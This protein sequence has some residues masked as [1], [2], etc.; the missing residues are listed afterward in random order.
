MAAEPSSSSTCDGVKSPCES[1]RFGTSGAFQNRPS[2][3]PRRSSATSGQTVPMTSSSRRRPARSS[4]IECTEAGA[5]VVCS[6]ASASAEARTA[7]R[8]ESVCVLFSLRVWAG[9]SARTDFSSCGTRATPGSASV[10]SSRRDAEYTTGR[11]KRT[12]ASMTAPSGPRV[13]AFRLRAMASP[14]SSP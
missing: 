1:T 10:M 12:G 14:L 8:S 7:S 4:D 13:S 6:T 11:G 5:V 9:S 3:R 2:T